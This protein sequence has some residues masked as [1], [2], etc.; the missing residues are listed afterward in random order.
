M[1]R[2]KK[3]IRYILG[4]IITKPSESPNASVILIKMVWVL[5]IFIYFFGIYQLF[6]GET[7]LGLMIVTCVLFLVAPSI[8]TRNRIKDIP[9]E[10]EFFLFI[11][12]LFQ[13]IAGEAQ[14]LYGTISYY[15]DIMHFFFPFLISIMGFTITYALYFAGKLKV[16]VGTMLVFVVLFTMGIGAFWEV[17]E[18]YND[19]LLVPRIPGWERAQ[20][21][22]AAS[23]FQDTMDD[24]VHDLWGGIAGAIV[25][26]RYILEA[27]YNKRLR[28]LLRE[29]V[30][31]FFSSRKI[32]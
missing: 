25:A 2:T 15:D 19:L 23:A 14:D 31:H 7:I 3:W 11:I 24:L 32:K 29:I 22:D 4:E 5:R 6:A 1:K 17:I 18:Y 9:L 13:F 10:L 12:V 16:S 8:F 28:E 26:S 30:K 20:A 21:H 27:K